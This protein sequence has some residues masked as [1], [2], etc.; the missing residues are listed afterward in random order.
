VLLLATLA[1]MVARRVRWAIM[2]L[3][4]MSSDPYIAYLRSL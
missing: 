4:E 2:P 1:A 3:V